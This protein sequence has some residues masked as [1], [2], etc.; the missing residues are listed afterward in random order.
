M[1]TTPMSSF[2][3]KSTVNY[4][5]LLFLIFLIFLL[6]GFAFGNSGQTITSEPTTKFM[7]WALLL[8][9]FSAISLVLGSALGL[10]WQPRP[11]VTAAFTAFGAGA[12]LA[13]L[14]I[15]LIAPTVM[16]FVA[17]KQTLT[18]Q[19]GDHDKILEFVFLLVGC[20]AGGLLFYFLN[21]ALNSSGGYLRKVSTTISYFNRQRKSRYTQMLKRISKIS[22]FRS[23]T[24]EHIDILVRHIRHSQIKAGKHIF[25]EGNMV[26]K[27]YLIESGEVEILKNGTKIK[28]L[29]PGN[30]L[31]E[32]AMLSR[33]PIAYSSL[34]LSN[35]KV[36]ELSYNDLIQLKDSCPEFH[37]I[38]ESES[39]HEF[40]LQEN[41]KELST[42]E[43]DWSDEAA[44][45]LHHTSYLPTQNEINETEKKSGSAPLS[46]WLGIFL[47][48]IPESFVIGAGFLIILSAKAGQGIVEFTD[49]IPYTLIA[50]LFLSN[51]PEAMSSSIGMKKMGWKSYKIIGMWTSLMLMTAVGA[52]VGYYYGSKIP[53]Y[54]EIGIEGVASGAM[55][56]MIAQT[57]IPEA[58]HIGGNRVTGLSTLAGYLAAVAFKVFE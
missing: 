1:Q 46:I 27:L 48:G 50:G 35:L 55:L 53:N 8:G 49:V 51:F 12:L 16:E 4:R 10:I 18:G 37:E 15:E 39:R 14:S 23:I 42:D 28:I 33:E 26:H 5:I 17:Q 44:R 19:A 56:T 32:T 25:Y 57:M 40:N 52:V 22:L 13:A 7:F 30:F 34:A 29:G 41:K 38:L 9:G 31:G 2:S 11:R 36:F 21:E 54:I 24:P 43:E 6:P 20:V 3:R 45:H 58:V 47:D